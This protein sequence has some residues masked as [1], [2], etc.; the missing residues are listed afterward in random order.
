M[1][2]KYISLELG[3]T[4]L[5]R[6]IVNMDYSVSTYL[7]ISTDVLKKAKNKSKC[8]SDLLIPYVDEVGKENVIAVTM[9]LSSLMD[10]N[11]A[12][13]YSSPMVDDFDNINLKEEIQSYLGLPVIL[14]KDV[15]ALL[16]YEIDRL[17]LEKEGIIVGIFLGTGLG[18]VF[19]IDGKIYR[20]FSGSASELGHIPVPGFD[21]DC[22][23]GK[24]GCI[25]LKAS[26][27]VL[28]QI[29]SKLQCKIED[30][31]TLYPNDPAVQSVVEHFAYAIAAEVSILDPR[32]VVL[33]GGI[34]S[35]P[36]F[37]LERLIELVKDNIRAP[38][39]RNSLNVI[40]AS[41]DDVAGVVGAAINAKQ[42]GYV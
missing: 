36:N 34:V 4:Y 7:K 5:R 39:P 6:A 3:G 38:Y 2:C 24:K 30:I 31:F 35:I 42:H 16:L 19:S 32:C 29:S 40:K 10:K 14:E 11:C 8:I 17:Q 13:I 28:A 27:K 25:E 20:G 1:S 22:G 37:P 21:E 41:N 15:N 18:N 9:A 12:F 23:C 26:G 33:G